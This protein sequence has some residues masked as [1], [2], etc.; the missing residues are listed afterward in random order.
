MSKKFNEG[1]DSRYLEMLLEPL[2]TCAK[3]TPNFGKNESDEFT[4]TRFQEVYGADP[5]YHWI[6][7]DSELMYAAHK[8]AGGM[9]SIYRQLGTG[10]ERL[11]RAVIGDTLRIAPDDLNW[12]YDVETD[13]G[14]SRRL[15]LDAKIG[16]T[17]I[18][19]SAAKTRMATWLF[20]SANSLG[21]SKN[22]SKQISGAIFEVRQGYKSA[23]AKRQNADLRNA[24][25]AFSE[26]DLP[27][28]AVLSTQI[29]DTLLR[30]YRNGNMLVLTGDRIGDVLK[31]TYAFMN[32]IVGY[33]LDRF[34][35]RNTDTL[36]REVNLILSRLLSPKGA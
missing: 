15:T 34:F 31:D 22:R 12:G 14:G 11:F 30:R 27:V 17:S 33:P 7:L 18:L 21:I 23:D 10:C 25:H 35:E 1:Q 8:A 20:T 16:C 6:G 36:R 26:N 13:D 28:I 24:A 29:S 4:V 3:Y 9:T 2:R 32:E 5:L 19:D